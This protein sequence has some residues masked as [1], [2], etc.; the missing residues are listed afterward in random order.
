M[1]QRYLV[2]KINSRIQIKDQYQEERKFTILKNRTLLK[3]IIHIV[4]ITQSRYY[5]MQQTLTV[6]N[7]I[8]PK[9]T[10][11]VFEEAILF[12]KDIVVMN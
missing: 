3:I 6:S 5:L 9:M 2:K 7:T 12:A 10:S 11:G 1:L 8:T 4:Y